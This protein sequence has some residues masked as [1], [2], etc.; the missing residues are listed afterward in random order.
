M[1]SNIKEFFKNFFP[2]IKQK[3]IYR[4]YLITIMVIIFL[5]GLGMGLEN[6]KQALFNDNFLSDFMAE[7]FEAHKN[8]ERNIGYAIYY[9]LLYFFVIIYIVPSLVILVHKKTSDK[10]WCIYIIFLSIVF[11]VF[12]NAYLTI[13]LQY[14]DETSESIYEM[15]LTSFIS[16]ST[17]II[18]IAGI[19]MSVIFSNELKNDAIKKDE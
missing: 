13:M 8:E 12:I 18:G 10:Y 16:V 5:I 14:H 7:C 2:N 4:A 19:K 1:C 11:L 3:S 17:I 6:N 15:H 9:L